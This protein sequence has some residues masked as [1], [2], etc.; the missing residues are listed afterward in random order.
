[1]QGPALGAVLH[2]PLEVGCGQRVHL[3]IKISLDAQGFRALH[4]ALHQGSSLPLLE[5][6]MAPA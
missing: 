2:V 4:G 3:V 5:R 1:M 6:G